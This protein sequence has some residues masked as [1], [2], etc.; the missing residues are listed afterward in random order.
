MC[1][2]TGLFQ[3]QYLRLS[4]IS[5]CIL[6]TKLLLKTIHTPLEFDILYQKEIF[7]SPLRFHE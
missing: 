1:I 6:N 7:V 5:Q 4:F 2:L 3:P